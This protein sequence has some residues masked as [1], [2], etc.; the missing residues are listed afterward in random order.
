[1]SEAKIK[2]PDGMLKAAENKYRELE[3]YNSNFQTNPDFL[4]LIRESLEAAM[5]WQKLNPQRPTAQQCFELRNLALAVNRNY[6]ATEP[7]AASCA[8]VAIDWVSR[9][10]DA[11]EPEVPEVPEA[12]KDLLIS[13]DALN[14]DV[15]DIPALVKDIAIESY[16]RGQK[17][18]MK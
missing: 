7:T 14:S 9:M 16:R 17:A 15:F 13:Q 8:A 3:S 10:Y 1:M 6:N 4:A 2:L 18:G 5:R 11:P 12:I